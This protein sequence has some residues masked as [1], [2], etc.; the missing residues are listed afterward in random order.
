MAQR[1]FDL[2]PG[3]QLCR[4]G[5]N[6][7]NHP[8]QL[9]AVRKYV[10]PGMSFLDIG[11]GAGTTIEALLSEK[12]DVK[13]RGVDRAKK[14]INWCR[15]MW[16]D[17]EFELED[18]EHLEEKD[19]SWDAAYS[20]HLVDHM[21]SFEIGLDEHCR[22]AKKLVIIVLWVT[23]DPEGEEHHIKPIFD[24]G[25]VWEGEFTNQ[26]SKKKMMDSIGK[27]K[28]WKLLEWADE[29]GAEF[30]GHNTVI[31]LEKNG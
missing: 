27:K 16:P 24:H 25:K 15:K 13:Y 7:P 3:G 9:Y 10:K 31:V 19:A 12:I 20:R 6:G 11:C 17:Q 14:Q 30:S 4:A 22:V 2:I 23:P 28:D 8:S 26:Y 29:V 18:A 1:W 5:G 21:P